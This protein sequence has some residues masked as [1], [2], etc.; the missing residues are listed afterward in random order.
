MTS[1]YDPDRFRQRLDKI[2]PP[3]R[4]AQGVEQSAKDKSDS[5]MWRFIGDIAPV[6]GTALGAV[7]GGLVGALGAPA[8]LG[9]SIIGGAAAGGALGGTVGKAGQ[10]LA[11]GQ[12][13]NIDSETDDENFKREEENAR[14]DARRQE[15]L[16]ILSSLRR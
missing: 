12:A 16:A 6:A 5:D 13:D 8:T 1:R 7:G 14:R 2:K 3:G 4:N 11:H 15:M 9:T 10:A